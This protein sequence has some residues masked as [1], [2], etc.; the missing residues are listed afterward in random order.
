MNEE[1]IIYLIPLIKYSVVKH[2]HINNIHQLQYFLYTV[3]ALLILCY[4]Y[5]EFIKIVTNQY[6]ENRELMYSKRYHYN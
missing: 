1:P 2:S 4:K 3:I 6:I 5:S